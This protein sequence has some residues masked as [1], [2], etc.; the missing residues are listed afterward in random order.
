MTYVIDRIEDGIAVLEYIDNRKEVLQIPKSSLPKGAREGHVLQKNGDTFT[1]SQEATQKRR[2]DL[3]A[4][5]DK[6]LNRA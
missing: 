1:I 2:E 3:R 6:I 5:M 4:R